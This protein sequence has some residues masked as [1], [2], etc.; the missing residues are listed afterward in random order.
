MDVVC[1]NMTFLWTYQTSRKGIPITMSL[2]FQ[3]SSLR[4]GAPLSRRL[5]EL[6]RSRFKTKR[7]GDF[8]HNI[9]DSSFSSTFSSSFHVFPPPPPPPPPPPSFFVSFF[10]S[11]I[12]LLGHLCN[13]S[14]RLL[15]YVC[16]CVDPQFYPSKLAFILWVSHSP[17]V[18]I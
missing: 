7:R 10:C 5:L 18:L 6:Q 17:I 12:R 4:L 13:G 2:I 9:S 15:G 16:L 8:K 14:I 11:S 3:S 1:P